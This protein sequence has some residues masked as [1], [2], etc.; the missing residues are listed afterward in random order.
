M[1]TQASAAGGF[2]LKFIHKILLAATAVIII[3][4]AGFGFYIYGNQQKNIAAA[5]DT[6]IAEIGNLTASTIANWLGGRVLL[7]ENVAQT[8]ANDDSQVNVDRTVQQK[9]LNDSFMFTYL[10]SKGGVMT[11]WPADELPEGYDPR[12][13]PWYQ[14]AVAAKASTLTEPYQDAASGKLIVTVATPLF[15]NGEA[16]GVVG[17]DL[18]ITTLAEIVNTLDLG[19][20]GEAFLVNGEG[21]IIAHKDPQ[22]TLKPMTEAYPGNAPTV[23]EGVQE[24][25]DSLFS[26]IAVPG[27]PTVKWYV[28]LHIDKP[29][30]FASLT[31]F[32]NTAILA[33]VLAV[34]AILVLLWLVVRQLVSKPVVAMTDAMNRLAAGDKTVDIPGTDR[35]DEIGAMSIAVNVFKQNAIEMERLAAEQER[36]KAESAEQQRAALNRM[37]DM[38]EQSVGGIVDAVAKAAGDMQHAAGR[39]S[40]TAEETNQRAVAVSAAAAET[41][42]SVQSV[43]AAAEE[44]AASITEISRQVTHSSRIAGDAVAGVDRTNTTVQSLAQA[45]QRIGEVVSLIQSIAAQTNLLALNATIEAARAGDAGKGFTVVASEVKALANQTEGATGEISTQISAIQGVS[46][47]A[48]TAMGTIAGT[49]QQ[50]NEIASAIAAAVEQQGAATK[51]IAGSVQQAADGTN[52]V[53]RNVAAVTDASGLVGQSAGQLLASAEDLSRLAAQLRDEVGGFLA[54]VRTA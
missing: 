43:A 27:L 6:R 38:F 50:I 2:G 13:R 28:G 7:V 21:V 22:W 33:T 39:L 25:G 34:A 15:R 37:A 19:G 26:F 49:I 4:F 16:L 29:A 3:A 36:M 35:R 24:Q 31:Q 41:T 32:R 11:M 45:A 30:A 18:D 17:G 9:V 20:I 5:L 48:V 44:L 54:K 10:G 53:S 52:E 1:A 46:S 12:Q 47:E 51:E 14:D 40:S 42:S 8:L 23:S